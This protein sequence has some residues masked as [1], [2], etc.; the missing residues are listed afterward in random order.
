MNNTHTDI[1]VTR[2]LNEQRELR[3]KYGRKLLALHAMVADFSDGSQQRFM[4]LMRELNRLRDELWY[5]QQKLDRVDTSQ[6]FGPEGLQV[7]FE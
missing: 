6:I 4:G 2:L 3:E 1:E 7:L 5:V